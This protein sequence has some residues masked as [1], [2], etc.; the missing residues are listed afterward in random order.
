MSLD[1]VRKAVAARLDAK[2]RAREVGLSNARQAIRRC[3]NAIRAVHRGE[4]EA[5]DR[6]L[7]EARDLLDV[8]EATLAAHPD[9]YY[10]GFVQDA[11][12]EY[13]EAL[14]ARALVAGEPLPPPEDVGVGDAPYLNGLAEAVGELRRHLLDVLRA[15]DVARAGELFGAMEEI[16]ALLVDVDYP[17]AMTGGLRRSTDVARAIIERTRSD[18]TLTVIQRDLADA[19]RRRADDAGAAGA[20]GAGGSA[21]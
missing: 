5:A 7:V 13:A 11:Q 21:G 3:A 12:K 15:G 9:V 17:D 18:L 8:A 14:A 6:L 10:A 16:H 19:L 1:E 2:H 20:G 4:R